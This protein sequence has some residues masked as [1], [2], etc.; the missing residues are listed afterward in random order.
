MMVQILSM[1]W[2]VVAVWLIIEFINSRLGKNRRIIS[3]ND[4]SDQGDR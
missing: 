4:E 1:F 3:I 2:L